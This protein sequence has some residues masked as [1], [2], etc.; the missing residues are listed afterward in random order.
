MQQWEAGLSVSTPITIELFHEKKISINTLIS[1]QVSFLPGAQ[2]IKAIV[3][4]SKTNKIFFQVL[5]HLVFRFLKMYYP[6]TYI[7]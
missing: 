7:F 6:N 1:E 3:K 2:D 5:P 4:K